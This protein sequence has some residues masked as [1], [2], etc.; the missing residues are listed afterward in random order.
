MI[1][2]AS[3][4]I[5]FVTRRGVAAS[6]AIAMLIGSACVVAWI[7][8]HMD[9]WAARDLITVKA[10]SSFAM[11]LAG[12]ALLLHGIGETAPWKRRLCWASSVATLLIG[13]LTLIQ[14]LFDIDLGIDEVF[15]SEVSGA[16]ATVSPN[17]MGPPASAGFTL[18]GLGSCLLLA[19]R[20]R[21]V[22]A[23]GVIVC[24]INLIPAV[25]Y[26]YGAY[27]LYGRGA[28]TG[29]AW[30][31]V[32]ALFS[33]GLGLIISVS[34]GPIMVQVL[35]DDAGGRLLR[36]LLPA[37]FGFPLCLGL[38]RTLGERAGFYAAPVGRG[39]LVVAISIVV[40][41]LVWQ[42]ARDLSV[43]GDKQLRAERAL[44]ESE[45]RFWHMADSAPVMIGVW[46]AT[47]QCTFLSRSW[48]EFTGRTAHSGLGEGWL[49]PIYPEDIPLQRVVFETARS[50][51]KA[52]QSDI[53]L[54]RHD[55]AARHVFLSATPRFAGDGQFL[56]LIGSMV[57]VTE[58]REQEAAL[59]NSERLYRAIGESIDYG[60]W[61]SDV[62]GRNTYASESFLNLV[63]MTQE[64]CAD[65]GWTTRLDPDE[66]E[67]AKRDWQA[68]VAAGQLWDREFHV[69]GKD[70]EWHPVLAR[71]VPVHNDRGDVIAW[72]G[73][74]L[75]ISRLKVAENELRDAAALL[76]G[77]LDSLNSLIAI[78]DRT[79]N[80]LRV[81]QA[82]S[83]YAASRGL[84]V[85]QFRAGNN[86]VS[87]LEQLCGDARR[88][89]AEAVAAL[90]GIRDVIAG[91]RSTFEAEYPWGSSDARRWF[92]L[93]VTQF[94]EGESF[95][96]VIS[97]DDISD[98]RQAE[99]EIRDQAERLRL[100]TEATR[101]GTWDINL[102]HNRLVVDD[103]GMEI[104]GF[105]TT[106]DLTYTS[107]LERLCPADRIQFDHAVMAA[108]DPAGS[109]RLT[110]E[111]RVIDSRNGIERWIRVTGQAFFTE[112][113][114]VRLIGTADDIALE[115]AA[116]AALQ[117]SDRRTRAVLEGLPQLV[118]TCRPDGE[119][120]FLNTRWVEFTGVP[121][122]EQLGDRW[123]NQVHPDDRERVREAWDAALQRERRGEPPD[124]RLDFRLRRHDGE[125][126]WFA[127]TGAPLYDTSN[128]LVRWVG[129]NTDITELLE[130]HDALTAAK[131][132]AEAANQAK[133]RFIAVLSHELRTPLTPVLMSI[134]AMELDPHLDP[135]RREEMKVIRRNV[136][137]EVKLIDDL[138]DISRITTGKLEL[139]FQPV[140]LNAAMRHVCGMCRASILEKGI[141]LH[142]V[143]G[144]D[145]G[146]IMGDAA[147]LQQVM[148]NILVNAVKFTPEGGDVYVATERQDDRVVLRVRD[149][150]IG[151]PQE[152]LPR[153]FDAFEQG[154]SRI[155]REF[156]GLGLGLAIAR[157]VV[158]MHNGT[159]RA[160]SDPAKGG[161]L[162]RVCLPGQVVAAEKD[163]PIPRPDP[164]EASTR[165]RML[166]VED[167]GDTVRV[168]SR[169]L[170][171]SGYDVTTAGSVRDAVKKLEGDP[172]DVIISDIG[173][174]DATGFEFMQRVREFSQTP[175][176]AMSG[177]GTDEDRRKSLAA[178]FDEHL[179]KPVDVIQLEDTIRRLMNQV[180]AR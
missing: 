19:S 127:V 64:E 156:G 112:G 48:Y 80:I 146:R 168:L 77:T 54:T 142:T 130:A 23:I 60:I 101:L 20:R 123:L 76:E 28:I 174:P 24:L 40:I 136:E 95:R 61:M 157:A 6:G 46:D 117:E 151:I 55:G 36:R 97:H 139:R 143:F 108:V 88:D 150:G 94:G 56:G 92:N 25:G 86:C 72:A 128:R 111:F 26:L 141:R 133:D 83:T 70:G 44:H 152:I 50:E 63:G 120:Q 29:I 1:A 137:V 103:R 74:H 75:D 171:L 147:R 99:Q 119:C 89:S 59:R 106:C 3:G 98:R 145:V 164:L 52:F 82:W 65:F 53:R 172:F 121:E 5:S 109:G 8:G 87:T 21:W 22:P 7:T 49:E 18:I 105:D 134:S 144:E 122:R 135:K 159:I 81:N 153:I 78:A 37:V 173:L 110:D 166:L 178:G 125:Y 179:V 32:V 175:A 115:K 16:R 91:D 102:V 93:H 66:A 126:R 43:L 124:Y 113:R 34:E 2:P 96:V 41:V 79:G 35:R 176:I 11:V 12:L 33:L 51:R 69:R 132:S 13:S 148:W 100:A 62:N 68:C 58:S 170:S 131:E 45:E 155:T 57:D 31:T 149:T 73:L 4:S 27:S 38:L 85:E 140:D 90:Q 15:F 177:F 161:T 71:G 84:S 17:R 114:A 118:W 9:R 116:E 42:A 67:A 169:L 30:P 154:D 162:I 107:L 138:L 10:N 158:Q 165:P 14:H 180:G 167:H 163:P 129:S 160:E 104:L 47:G 39:I